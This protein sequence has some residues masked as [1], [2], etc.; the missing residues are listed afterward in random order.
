VSGAMVLRMRGVLKTAVAQ[1]LCWSRADALI[2]RLAEAHSQPLVV[3]YHRVVEDFEASASAAI[4]AMLTSARM[5]EEQLDW[6]GSRYRFVTLD[7]L[8]RELEAGGNGPRPP[9]AVTFD[10]GY[11]DVHDLAMPVLERKGIPAAVFV[12]TDVIERG[13]PQ[14]HDRLYM[15]ICRAFTR[16]PDP[17]RALAELLA[18]VGISAAVVAPAVVDP[19]AT[20][21][22][23]LRGL[24][25]G[26]VDRIAEAIEAEVGGD[27]AAMDGM[28]PLTWQMLDEMARAG[29][30]IGS[31]TRTHAWLTRERADE[32]IEEAR[33]SREEIE[34]RLGVPVRHF[35]YPDG[36]F[37]AATVE[38]VADA[39]YRFGYPT[40]THR[41][42][43]H[44]LLTVPRRMLWEHSCVDAINRF[45]AAVMSCNVR[46]VWSLMNGCGQE[47][48]R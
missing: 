19:L 21:V 23:L 11:R 13:G 29:M 6:I 15:L 34:R 20:V 17:G 7:E 24:S 14:I 39:G 27:R 4:P 31:H 12:V 26:D 5:L 45:S 47:H 33:G 37:D 10:D 1:A 48:G 42:L 9:A 32:V 25:R 30:V 22:A 16:W 28:R 38:S 2:G 43:R 35:A 46:G 36:R 44:P 40:C 41:D 3:G 18:A 8:G